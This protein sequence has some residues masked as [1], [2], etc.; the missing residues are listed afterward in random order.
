MVA[1]D[2]DA[3]LLNQSADS[4]SQDGSS[5][6]QTTP[7]KKRSKKR[8]KRDSRLE[9][10]VKCFSLQQSLRVLFSPRARDLEQDGELEALNGVRVCVVGC[11][12]LGNTYFYM[13]K[14]PL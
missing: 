12:I 9:R 10:V 11:I 1:A 3:L 7:A 8:G 2:V 13:L 6:N 5:T 14:G 4:S